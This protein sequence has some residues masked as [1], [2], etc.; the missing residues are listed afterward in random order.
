MYK[1]IQ[2]QEKIGQYLEGYLNPR[3]SQ[4]SC[5]FFSDEENRFYICRKYSTYVAKL[6]NL[7][8]EGSIST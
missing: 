3:E 4:N 2:D 6:K 8:P 7:Y 5:S 1:K